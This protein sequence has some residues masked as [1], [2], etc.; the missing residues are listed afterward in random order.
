VRAEDRPQNLQS[1]AAPAGV[2]DLSLEPDSW[3]GKRRSHHLDLTPRRLVAISELV[4]DLEGRDPPSRPGR[5]SAHHF[6]GGLIAYVLEPTALE[7]CGQLGDTRP[8]E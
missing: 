3:I 1:T 4:D 5:S 7:Q 2:Q 8:R 6:G